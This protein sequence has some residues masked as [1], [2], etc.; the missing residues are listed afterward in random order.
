M[1]GR[2]GIV[3]KKKKIFDTGKTLPKLDS[4]WIA[5]R[6]GVSS[7]TLR[8][9]ET[10]VLHHVKIPLAKRDLEAIDRELPMTT[11]RDREE[12]LRAGALPFFAECWFFCQNG[13]RVCVDADGQQYERHLVT[14]PITELSDDDPALTEPVKVLLSE[15]E[16]MVL[17]SLL[18]ERAARSAFGLFREARSLY[19]W[20][21]RLIREH[22]GVM[23]ARIGNNV[24]SKIVV[25]GIR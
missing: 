19:T 5:R 24:I 25:S 16:L 18:Q 17:N 13:W 3:K 6:L 7:V 11:F 22:R 4:M 9:G 20:T 15:R 1:L 14:F 23:H 12:F 2:G 10:K 8:T 21:L